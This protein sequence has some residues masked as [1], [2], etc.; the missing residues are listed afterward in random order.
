[1]A[2]RRLFSGWLIAMAA[3][4]RSVAQALERAS[5][6]RSSA[7]IGAAPDPVMA[8]LAERYP[9]APA[10]W[11][12]HVAERTSQLAAAGETPLSLNSDPAAWP[13]PRPE[14]V[15]PPPAITEAPVSSD[16][17][18][19]EPAPRRDV[20]VPTLAALSDRSSE[21][22]RRPDLELRPRPRP[23]FAT[24]TRPPRPP[25]PAASDA[26][27]RRPRAPLTFTSPA[28]PTVS[29][30]PVTPDIPAAEAVLR[31][32]TWSEA[33]P[34]RLMAPEPAKPWLDAQA[35][36]GPSSDPVLARTRLAPFIS[37]PMDRPE[38]DFDRTAATPAAR[39]P[40][41]WF[42]AKPASARA[43]RALDLS[44][45]PRREGDEGGASAETAITL[46]AAS[47]PHP[48]FAYSTVER[49]AVAPD[50]VWRALT[51]AAARRALSL[52]LAAF[53]PKPRPRADHVQ[54]SEPTVARAAP[55]IDRPSSEPRPRRAAPFFTRS[56][57]ERSALH[58][59]DPDPFIDWGPPSRL[60]EDQEP[61]RA[62]ERRGRSSPN[63]PVPTGEA[64]GQD[65]RATFPTTRSGASRPASRGFT[66][67]P[68]DDR[69]PALPP[70][71][72]AA[73]LGVEA[74][75]PRWDQLARE[76]EEG[77]WSV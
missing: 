17:R 66:D 19:P 18:R 7:A 10:H 70:T 12:A 27:P 52:A 55:P 43:D 28:S 5:E 22:W 72:I 14:T 35:T 29:S 50:Q 68:S 69:W 64:Q 46:D 11:L 67:A 71:T 49:Q 4:A 1:M 56:P 20:E 60:A 61:H 3:L 23:V 8:A 41:S 26:A 47:Q 6:D 57:A 63:W 37:K 15:A 45:E 62:A 59:P 39:R 74:A 65:R 51:P 34:S 58:F 2:L 38:A 25:R 16:A 73:P 13:T 54:A 9:G 31:Q 32:P 76:Q 75:S 36:E 33:P 77:R 24:E 44:T 42:F 30:A 40:R 48:S 53:R 21:V